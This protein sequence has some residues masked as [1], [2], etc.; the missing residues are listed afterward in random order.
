M[1][2]EELK[3]GKYKAIERY[4]DVLTGKV[5]RVSITMDKNTAKSR[6]EAQAILNVKID[7]A[8]GAQ[9]PKGLTLEKLIEYYRNDQ[10]KTVKQST[11]RRNY[12]A[13]ETIMRILGRDVLCD[14]L[15]AGYVRS[16]FLSTGKEPGTLNEHLTRFK[17][18][19]RWGYRND[20]I[21]DISY[22]DKIERFKDKSHRQKIQDKFLEA[23]EIKEL[24]ALM[25]IEKWH[26]LA[27]F[28]ILTGLRVGEA[29]ALEISDVDTKS[30]QIHVTKTY[31]MINDETAPPKTPCSVRDVYIQAELMPLSKRL[32]QKAVCDR[33][34]TGC[35]LFFQDD[36]E[37][38]DYFAFNKYL[39]SRIQKVTG[40]RLTSHALRHTHASLMLENGISVDAISRRLGHEDSRITK[41]I[42]LHA[43]KKLKEKENQRMEEV[44]IL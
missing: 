17:A 34:I 8:L 13:C 10:E 1:W 42:Y 29:L 12:F 21:K 41:E 7:K 18:L 25:E 3:N 43:T 11:Y 16:R 28:L 24:L 15:T 4:T 30:R 14:K 38:L 39:S 36:G 19:I 26:D 35:T 9:S 37:R 22:L 6:K 32:K 33:M 31:D 40:R 2:I 20:Y 27:E 23:S 44:Q 5:K